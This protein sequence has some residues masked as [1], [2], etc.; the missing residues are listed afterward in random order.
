MF[1]IILNGSVFASFIVLV[2]RTISSSIAHSALA[3]LVFMIHLIPEVSGLL[4]AAIAGGVASKAMTHEK[5]GSPGFKNVFK[6]ATILLLI[7][8]GLVL[9]SALLETFITGRLFQLIF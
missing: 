5:I 1:L 9:I 7:A 6:D 3:M 4:I 2:I 8:V